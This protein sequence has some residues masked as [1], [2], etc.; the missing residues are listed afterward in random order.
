[1]NFI[2]MIT[3]FTNWVWNWPILIV[4]IT[5]GLILGYQT[6]FIQIRHFGYAMK[7]TFGKMFD[8]DV[9]GEGSVSPFQ[10]AS[11]A[12]ASSIGAANIVVAPAIIFTAGPG[13]IVWMWV[14]G[15]IGQATKFS[16]IVLGIKYR[17]VNE[18]GDYV[19]GAA[20]TFKNGIKGNLGKIM[21][22]LVAF[23][24]M[25]EI[26]PSITVQTISATAPLEQ[27]GL[28]R[29]ISAAAITVLVVL[30]VYGG[31]QRIGQITE[32][33]VPVMAG[34]YVICGLVVIFMNIQN[35]PD[36]VS[37]IFSSAFNPQAAITG[38]AWGA[39]LEMFKAGA[40]RGSYSNEAGMGSAA[41]AHATAVT[42]HPVRQGLWGI[43]EVVST[44]LMV[45]TI[46]VLV[47]MLSG[48]YKN[49]ALKDIAVER[50]F[51]NAFGSIGTV[52]I[53]ISLFMFVIST[54]IV[55][56]FYAERLG[57]YLFGLH[58]GKLMRFLACFMVLLGGFVTFEGAG[59]FLDFTLGLVVFVNMIGMIM[60]SGEVREL[61]DDFFTN[62]K[63]FPGAKKDK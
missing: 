20:Y 14:A 60:L 33:L 34:L 36:A 54:V 40:A 51:N 35:L 50:A 25:L 58:F 8:S 48:N 24:F 49:P 61:T 1:M 63:Y 38:G 46:S 19:G 17:E 44:T 31:I 15:I 23:F 47:V 30:V 22:F 45:C 21:G 13:A 29:P 56:V 9:G 52:I 37:A 32:K 16:E 57:E 10:A 39:F 3:Q 5:G 53:A 12:L 62:P 43:F 55:I 4:L 2:E 6:R 7:Q 26:L 28:S 11:A 18:E 42:D 41:Y 27:L 59:V